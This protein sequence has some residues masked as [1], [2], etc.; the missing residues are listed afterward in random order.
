MSL[1]TCICPLELHTNYSTYKVRNISLSYFMHK[2]LLEHLD[3]HEE[4]FIST[5]SHYQLF[6][7]LLLQ[8]KE[9][10]SGKETVCCVWPSLRPLT[11]KNEIL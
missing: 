9:L 4:P 3:E 6:I 11:F 1:C 2:M 7:K 10:M 8:L 5:T